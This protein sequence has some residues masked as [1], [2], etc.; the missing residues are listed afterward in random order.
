MTT[1]I[2][3]RCSA[4]LPLFALS[5]AMVPWAA[6]CKGAVSTNW[7]SPDASTPGKQSFDVSTVLRE[8]GSAPRVSNFTLVLDR[9]AR[10]AVVGGNGMGAV[11][12]FTTTDGRTYRA[13]HGFAVGDR[14]SACG[15][16]EVVH[17]EK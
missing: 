4:V 7:N 16:A 1:P 14:D 15:P 13:N 17:Y 9:V 10:T 6:G 2:R 5:V 11:I 3:Q 8:D 12:D